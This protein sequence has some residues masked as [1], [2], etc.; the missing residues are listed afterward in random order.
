MKWFLSVS[1]WLATTAV[2]API[3][4]FAVIALAG[5]HGGLLPEPLHRP[6]LLAAW[7]LLLGLPAWVAHYVHQRSRKRA[8]PLEPSAGS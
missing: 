3:C 8:E 5:P 6:V 4:Y 1:A 2:L 7:T